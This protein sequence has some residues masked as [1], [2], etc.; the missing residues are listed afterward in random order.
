MN[1][2]YNLRL[3]RLYAPVYDRLFGPVLA[4]ARRHA[5]RRLNPHPGERL[6]MPGVG[7][8]LDLP[9]LPAGVHVVAG[10]LSQA[11]LAQ[12]RLKPC[13]ASVAFQVMDAQN[14]G[15][16]SPICDAVLLNLILSVVP[17]GRR[18]FTEAWRVVRPGGRLVIFDKFL[19]EGEA[20]SPARQRLGHLIAALGTDPNRRLSDILADQATAVRLNEPSLLRGQYRI[21]LLEKR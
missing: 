6:L 21:V 15:L 12:A 13:A 11:M 20:L 5:L 16:A 3:Y 8:G 10:D 4:S 17:D 18:A 19:P 7:T 1:N 14:L 9:Y 2:D